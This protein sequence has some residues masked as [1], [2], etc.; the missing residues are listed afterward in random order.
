MPYSTS[1]P[2]RPAQSY[3][4]DEAPPKPLDDADPQSGD[5]TQW[6]ELVSRIQRSES[7]AMEDLYRAFSRG[8]RFH[9]CKHIAH[10]DLD[11]R[12]HDVFV[13]VV[14]AIRNGTLREPER[15]MGFV[16]TV[17]RRQVAASI[18]DAIQQRNDHTEFEICGHIADARYNPE[19][20]AIR[21]SRLRLMFSALGR[22]PVRDREILVRYYLHEQPQEQICE[23]MALT[24]TQFR[25]LKSRAKARFGEAG[26]RSLGNSL[27]RAFQIDR[28]HREQGQA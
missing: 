24:E 15:L 27:L 25:L 1:G 13:I 6:A 22:I 14:Q 8:V 3:S 10:E 20:Q 23:A 9:L 11:D 26:K 2:E 17:V 28:V 16:R 5:H 12:V 19:Q 4:A 21:G 18:G 7:G